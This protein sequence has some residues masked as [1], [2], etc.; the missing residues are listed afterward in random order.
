MCCSCVAL[1][2]FVSVLGVAGVGAT[3]V[4]PGD[5]GSSNT[6]G[7][8]KAG[9]GTIQPATLSSPGSSA[10]ALS[11][12]WAELSA[13]GVHGPSGTVFTTTPYAAAAAAGSGRVGMWIAA[14]HA[15]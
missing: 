8:V 5:A 1:R 12:G 7:V 4:Q 3:V 2:C 14:W 15:V 13:A 9:R 11:G 6:V 10:A